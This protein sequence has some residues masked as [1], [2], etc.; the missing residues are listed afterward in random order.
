MTIRI[1]HGRVRYRRDLTNIRY[2]Y[3]VTI[4]PPKKRQMKNGESKCYGFANFLTHEDAA[5][6]ARAG[7]VRSQAQQ[8][9][10]SQASKALRAEHCLKEAPGMQD[11]FSIDAFRIVCSHR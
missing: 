9:R 8:R 4:L 1:T 3:L 2:A 6:G 10:Y 7:R 5:A 11:V